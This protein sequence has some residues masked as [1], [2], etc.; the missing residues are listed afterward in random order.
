[1]KRFTAPSWLQFSNT[2][3]HFQSLKIFLEEANL[4]PKSVDPGPGG[5]LTIEKVL[6]E[7]RQFDLSLSLEKAVIS[8]ND[9]SEFSIPCNPAQS[10]PSLT[11][12]G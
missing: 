10:S 11:R 4:D 7:K 6:D 8:D 9:E 2:N 5:G 3:C 1:M 12:L